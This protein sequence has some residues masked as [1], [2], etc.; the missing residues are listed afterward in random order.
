MARYDRADL[1][2]IGERIWTPTRLFNVREGFAREDGALLEPR[3]DADD[4]AS[5]DAG[6]RGGRIGVRER[7]GTTSGGKRR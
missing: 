5:G 1:A 7:I 4:G 6:S 2:T 3:A